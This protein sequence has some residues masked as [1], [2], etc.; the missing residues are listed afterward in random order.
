MNIFRRLAAWW[1]ACP[2]TH[3][4]VYSGVT[5]CCGRCGELWALRPGEFGGVAADGP[6]EYWVLVRA[7]KP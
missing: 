4:W 2:Q 6:V 3:L 7:G 5:C 1:R